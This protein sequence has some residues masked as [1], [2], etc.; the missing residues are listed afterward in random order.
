M[1]LIKQIKEA[2]N[3]AKKLV[4]DTQKYASEAVENAKQ[5][6][7]RQLEQAALVAF[8]SRNGGAIIA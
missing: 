2:E 6:R 3:K 5:E 7:N 8:P 1:E 4:E